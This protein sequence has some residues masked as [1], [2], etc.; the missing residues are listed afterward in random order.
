MNAAPRA[1]RR[2]PWAV[3]S[4]SLSVSMS[5]NALSTACCSSDRPERSSKATD[6]AMLAGG[7]RAGRANNR[8]STSPVSAEALETMYC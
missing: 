3:S 1:R 5:R 2:A 6:L 7:A 8:T 4:P